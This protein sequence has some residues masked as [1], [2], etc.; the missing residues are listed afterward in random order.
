MGKK[1]VKCKTCGEDVAK[2]ATVCPHCGAKLKK[3]H[4][5]LGIIII[6]FG[7]ALIGTA[8]GGG[9]SKSGNTVT[10]EEFDKIETGMTYEEVVE[11]I[12]FDGELISQVDIGDGDQYKT[13]I[14]TWANP[15]G[16]NM[17]ATFQGGKMVS[18][19]QTGLS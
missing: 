8:F 3:R 6:I 1:L 11:I 4:P 5:I 12:G 2:S 9:A 17:N 10:K 14:Y 7:L 13:E 16:A 19:A 18:K 15:G